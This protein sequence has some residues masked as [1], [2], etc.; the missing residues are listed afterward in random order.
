MVPVHGM[1]WRWYGEV[2][3]AATLSS[4]ALRG[5]EAS[6]ELTASAMVVGPVLSLACTA[7]QTTS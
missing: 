6:A 1:A 7:W 3:P 2:A 5:I 4:T